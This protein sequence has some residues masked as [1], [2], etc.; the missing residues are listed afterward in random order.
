MPAAGHVADKMTNDQLLEQLEQTISK[1]R[2]TAAEARRLR[3]AAR[4]QM[5]RLRKLC[6]ELSFQR[7]VARQNLQEQE[8]LLS[9]V[10]TSSW[11]IRR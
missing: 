10:R 5:E 7:V 6:S 2:S 3:N 11:T 9:A 8:A 4:D 1:A